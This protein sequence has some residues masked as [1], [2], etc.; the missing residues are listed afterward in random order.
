MRSRFVFLLIAAFAIAA[1]GKEYIRDSPYGGI[2]TEDG[3]IRLQAATDRAELSR[4]AISGAAFP[5]GNDIILS[6]RLHVEGQPACSWFDTVRFSRNGDFW[7]ADKYWPMEGELSFMAYSAQG[8]D[9]ETRPVTSEEFNCWE[10]MIP[11]DYSEQQVDILFLYGNCAEASFSAKNVPPTLSFKHAMAR[12]VFE[13][14]SNVAWDEEHNQGVVI[15]Y[16]TVNNVLIKGQLRLFGSGEVSFEAD[17]PELFS[18]QLSVAELTGYPVLNGIDSL[19]TNGLLV[20]P[21]AG[22]SITITYTTWDGCRSLQHS[23]EYN[24]QDDWEANEMYVYKLAFDGESLLLELAPHYLTITSSIPN[25]LA[26]SNPD[27]TKADAPYIEYSLD[28][29]TWQ[30]VP[31]YTG[32]Y[33]SLGSNVGKYS[34]DVLDVNIAN[35]IKQGYITG[36]EKYLIYFDSVIYLRGNN[37]NGLSSASSSGKYA[38]LT[39]IWFKECNVNDPGKTISIDGDLKYLL[40]Y[41]EPI[42]EIPDNLFCFAML[43]GGNTKRFVNIVKAP[44]LRVNKIN[45]IG[46]MYKT[47]HNTGI[48]EQPVLSATEVSER[49]YESTFQ[50][51]VNLNTAEALPINVTAPYCCY[52]TYYNSGLQNPPAVLPATQLSLRC[53][54][55]MFY[56]SK[57]T[58]TPELPAEG[59]LSALDSY[60]E[61]Y[62]GMFENC[63]QLTRTANIAMRYYSACNNI[64]KNCPKLSNITVYDCDAGGTDWVSGVSH[65]GIINLSS[66]EIPTDA[67]VAAGRRDGHIPSGWHVLHLQSGY[68]WAP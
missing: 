18:R 49:C 28:A 58:V 17:S 4:S 59:S 48:I 50:N 40:S 32:P 5:A 24:V 61:C 38:A 36:R 35:N 54:Q 39:Q 15:D 23:L 29:E 20:P 43:F 10:M 52:R 19:R 26:I 34:Y 11:E 68:I 22:T 13:A 62:S 33:G 47:F 7:S 65:E 45:A 64:F 1:C 66:P 60:A 16:I 67:K 41:D 27:Y 21:Q 8:M 31:W 44:D 56:G 14:E 51:C 37:P 2:K 63:S 53:Y 46:C 12:L 57:V 9:F 3:L 25:C 6:A 55:Q 42:E 30:Q